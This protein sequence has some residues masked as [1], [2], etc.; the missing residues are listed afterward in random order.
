[1]GDRTI[2]ESHHDRSV[3]RRSAVPAAATPFDRGDLGVPREKR[4]E[5]DE[6]TGFTDDA[7][8]SDRRI[9][10]PVSGRQTSRIDAVVDHD[11]TTA[12]EGLTNGPC[13]TGKTTG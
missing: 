1:M 4:H 8:A 7:A 6:V 13:V 2:L 5:V 11:G 9:V 10:E 12:G 3:L